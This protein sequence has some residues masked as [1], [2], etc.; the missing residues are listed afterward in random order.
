MYIQIIWGEGFIKLNEKK[1]QGFFLYREGL[2][3]CH[4]FPLLSWMTS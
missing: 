1:T 2:K 3:E 4:P